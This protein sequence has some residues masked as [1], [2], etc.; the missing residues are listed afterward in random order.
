MY[1]GYPSPGAATGLQATSKASQEETQPV[2]S[3]EEEKKTLVEEI[4]EKGFQAYAEE[5]KEKKKEELRA[6]ILGEMG[7]S[8]E[9]LQSMSPEMRGQIEKMIA[10]E[11]VK[12]MTA[13]G[14]LKR[15]ENG[16]Q[17][18]QKGTK[19]QTGQ[20][21]MALIDNAGVGL[22]PLLALQEIDAAKNGEKPQTEK[23]T[24]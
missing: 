8:E 4:R 9:D 6:K 24:G 19:P 22:G 12:R 16:M 17:G 7:L 23:N 5:L 14:E 21:T 18:L 10:N 2:V 3:A 11:I 13:E 20:P 15:Q 1:G